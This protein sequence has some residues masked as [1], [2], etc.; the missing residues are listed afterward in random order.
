[1][2]DL[3]ERIRKHLGKKIKQWY[4]HRDKRIYLSIRPEAIKEVTKF[5]FQDLELRFCTASGIDTPGGFEIL[6]HFSH[7]ETGVIYSVKVYI[8]NKEKP[9]IESITPI[10]KS[11]EWI[12]RE[13]WELLGINFLNHPNLQH[14]ILTE[15]W[16]EGEYPLRQKTEDRRQ[17]T[18]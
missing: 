4:Q 12:E 1:M 2:E 8:E 9:E 15:D 11:A 10:I 13:M 18:E 17:R 5:L 7:D 3:K 16:P 6:Y 14:L